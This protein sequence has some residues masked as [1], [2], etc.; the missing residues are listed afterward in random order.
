MI[1]TDKR[2]IF[3]MQ[4]FSKSSFPFLVLSWKIHNRKLSIIR[5]QSWNTF[6]CSKPHML[7]FIFYLRTPQIKSQQTNDWLLKKKPTNL[8]C[9]PSR[10][11]NVTIYFPRMWKMR[12]FLLLWC[13]NFVATSSNMGIFSW[14][15][16]RATYIP[17]SSEDLSEDDS[18]R[19]LLSSLLAKIR[20]KI[21]MKNE[22]HCLLS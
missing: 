2:H 15:W 22:M 7:G 16:N 12:G 10:M 17:R 21:L 6:S 20:K 18:L 1:V 13:S 14:M 11:K 4:A 3:Y 5:P 9:L 19:Y 8:E